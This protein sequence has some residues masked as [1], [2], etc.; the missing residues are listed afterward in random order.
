VS[1]NCLSAVFQ[2]KDSRIVQA[3]SSLQSLGQII[4]DPVRGR[5]SDELRNYAL[6]FKIIEEKGLKMYAGV[7]HRDHN[8]LSSAQQKWIGSMNRTLVT[9]MTEMPRRCTTCHGLTFARISKTGNVYFHCCDEFV[10]VE[11]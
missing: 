2:E 1:T 7:G 9:A 3:Q 10:D 5:A 8:V 6:Q 11:L 4:Q